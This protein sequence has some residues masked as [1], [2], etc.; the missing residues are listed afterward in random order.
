ML[1]YDDELIAAKVRT[2]AKRNAIRLGLIHL[3]YDNLAAS[4][5]DPE[6]A[7]TTESL[8]GVRVASG[9]LDCKRGRQVLI[10]VSHAYSARHKG[11]QPIKP[12]CNDLINIYA[13]LGIRMC[14]DRPFP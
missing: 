1:S 11:E 12:S 13:L 6:C 2:P 14:I 3:V 7:M 8:R 10:V 5:N 9:T 4:C